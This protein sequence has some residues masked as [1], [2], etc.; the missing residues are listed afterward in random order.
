MNKAK[1]IA[2][3]LRNAII[4]QALG[5][6]TRLPE[7]MIGKQFGTSR[8]IVRA[9]LSQ[10]AAEGL[11]DLRHNR[12]A[13]VAEPS[14][15]EACDTFELRISVEELVVARLAGALSEDQKQRLR[16]HVSEED[17]ARRAGDEAHS[18]RLAGEFH[19][20]MAELTGST[21][22][23]KYMRELT[24]KCCL[25]LALYSRPHSSD[26]AVSE[27]QHILDLLFQD[28]VSVAVKANT[29]HLRSV[30]DR[31]LIKPPHRNQKN[32]SDVLSHY[33]VK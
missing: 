9:A 33:A 3:T 18:L 26:C 27:H 4:E 8:T 23:I 21:V 29:D 2:T 6:G 16:D 1:T 24:S 5:P 12:S 28:D 32:I 15:D 14:W 10:L 19:S 31:A 30:V 22:L 20:L 7:D 25:I 17:A 13:A 11:V